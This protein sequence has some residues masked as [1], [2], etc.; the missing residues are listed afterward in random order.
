MHPEDTTARLAF[1]EEAG[2]LKDVLRSGRTA[3]GRPEDSAAHSW[4]LAVVAI[5]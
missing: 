4:R 2:A 5:L 1:L 3:A